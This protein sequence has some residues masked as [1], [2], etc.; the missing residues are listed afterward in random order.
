MSS[1]QARTL[2]QRLVVLQAL[3]RQGASVAQAAR[4]ESLCRRQS[5]PTFQHFQYT[6]AAAVAEGAVAQFCSTAVPQSAQPV[7]RANMET[8]RQLVKSVHVDDVLG[9]EK[10]RLAQKQRRCPKCHEETVIEY[11]I[12]RRRGDEMENTYRFCMHCKKRV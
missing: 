2:L 1:P 9:D 7:L 5:C 11:I 8:F 12:Q 4:I 3:Q 10:T 6:R